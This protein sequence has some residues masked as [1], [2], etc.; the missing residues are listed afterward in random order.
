MIRL[1][2]VDDDPIFRLGLVHL[3]ERE[4][5]MLV[6]WE[7]GSVDELQQRLAAKPV[8]VVLMDLSLGSDQDSLAA[9]TAVRQDF[10]AVRVIVISASLDWEAAAAARAAGA[11]GY[12]PKGLETADM[13]AAIRGLASPTF[14]K[15]AFNNMLEGRPGA[16][17]MPL[18]SRIGLSKRER[19]VLAELRRGRTNKEI[20]SRL[21]V[22]TTTVNKHVQQVLRKL[23]VHTRAQAVA[24]AN[25]DAAG[26][27]YGVKSSRGASASARSV[28]A[29][30]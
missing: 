2:V 27:P 6:M 25:A 28:D 7:L 19:E 10:D 30:C 22:S 18:P 11:S 29:V 20:A 21:G 23:H 17:G 8:D 26:R 13:I 15:L 4:P 14:G 12:L 9:T 1:G 3:V 5:D 16:Q 24:M